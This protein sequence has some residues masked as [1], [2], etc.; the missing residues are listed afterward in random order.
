[1]TA[2]MDPVT[3]EIF[4]EAIVSTVA[5]MRI[6]VM[7][8]AFSSIIYEG[9][10][11]SC[12][13]TDGRGRL[14][15]LSREDSPLHVGPMNLQVPQALARFSDDL[16]PGDVLLANDPFTSGTHLNDVLVMSPFFVDGRLLMVSCI[17]A[18]WGDI[19]GMVPGSISGRSTEIFQEGVRIPILRIHERGQPNHTALEL[20]FA[21]VRKP[22]DRRGDFHAQLATTRTAEERLTAI[23]ARFGVAAVEQGIEQI[24]DR[25]EARMRA[26]LATLPE[27]TYRFEDYLDS[28]GNAPE[29]VRVAVAATVAGSALTVDFTGSSPQRR[30]PVNASLAVTSTATFVTVKGL[31]DPT[32]H[33]NEGAFRPITVIAPEGSVTNASYPAPMGGFT[34]IYRRVSP[35]LIGALARAAPARIAGDTK[36]T[37]NH[38]YV[39]FYEETEV[40]SIFYEYPAGGTGG[41]LEHDGSNTV[42]EWDTGDFSSIQSVELVE[43]EHACE[44]EVCA[45]RLDSAGPGRHRGGQGMRRVLRVESPRALFSV[46]SDR[47]VFPPYGVAGGAQGACN[48]F[49]VER[50]G[51]LVE[52]APVPGKVGAFPLVAGDRVVFLSAGGGGYGDPLERDPLDVAADVAD[53]RVSPEAARAAYGVVLAADGRV[54]QAAST[55][56]RTEIAAGRPRLLAH[57]V[58]EEAHGDEP[59]QRFLLNPATGLALGLAE[60]TLAEASTGIGAPI[61]GRVHL[62]ATMPEGALGLAA[63]SFEILAIEAGTPLRVSA[64]ARGP[65]GETPPASE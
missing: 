16:A 21:N 32:G 25:T 54:D 7:R 34:E 3:L 20:L 30:G 5:D 49:Y 50:D 53:G 19:G 42:R 27:G 6:T 61:R 57:E 37:A 18:H 35:T 46:L 62:A 29:P 45:L 40:R 55:R 64:L 28:D 24:L 44:V 39:A 9:Q 47:N 63:K 56:L 15:A 43:H 17:R 26:R 14:L 2:E 33:I 8:T 65:A 13:L 52:P 23:V 59:P 12:A 48:R 10:D 58:G 11:F 31:L 22:R 51:A 1:M 38:V 60:G 36:G 41:F 4:H